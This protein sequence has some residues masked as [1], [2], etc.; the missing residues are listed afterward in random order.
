MSHEIADKGRMP[1]DEEMQYEACRIIF[2]SEVLS[3]GGPSSSPAWLRDLIMSNEQIARGARLSPVRGQA[4]NRMSSLHI[5]GKDNLFDDDSLE[6][7]LREFVKARTL[8][9]LTAMDGELQVEACRIVSRMEESSNKPFEMVANWLIRLVYSSAAWLAPFRRRCHLPRSEDL[10]DENQRSRDPTTIDSTVHNYSRLEV[11]L[12]QFVRMQRSLGA[13]PTDADLQRQARLIIYEYEDGWNQTAADNDQWL[14]DFKQRHMVEPGASA[15][16]NTDVAL[17][18]ESLLDQTANANMASDL[19]GDAH[20]APCG[21]PGPQQVLNSYVKTS[22]FFLNDANCYRRLAR[23]LIRW[24]QVTMSPNNPNCHVPSDEEIQHQARWI[25]YDECVTPRFTFAAHDQMLTSHHS[26]DP[27][28]QTAADNAEWLRR[29]KRDA[30]ILKDESGP[31]LPETDAWAVKLG[32]S[33]FAP[34][35]A[36]PRA[37][38]QPFRDGSTVQIPLRDGAKLFNAPN[39]AANKW[40]N[41]F[42]S[43]YPAPATVFC[44]R[45]LEKGLTDY[46]EGRFAHGVFPADDELKGKAREILATE[47]TAA[48]DSILLEK[49]KRLMKRRLE[50]GMSGA[51]ESEATSPEGGAPLGEQEDDESEH[52]QSPEGGLQLSAMPPNLDP[53]MSDNEIN[54]MLQEMQFEFDDGAALDANRGLAAGLGLR[55]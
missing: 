2:G 45:E 25:L 50:G 34:P 27:W 36:F 46:V 9:G 17:T 22:P 20:L 53:N 31:G 4:E 41:S 51:E 54:D 8:L 26:D 21:M 42:T 37:A 30:G 6:Q 32:G 52:R 14:S 47:T 49:F 43:R 12:A 11:E 38:M 33:G 35:Y 55:F 23:E 39:E 7:Q 48:D 28:N 40:L 15:V 24:A 18:L 5:N 3:Q 13:E 19:S 16:N 1:T 44:S 29:F 10:A